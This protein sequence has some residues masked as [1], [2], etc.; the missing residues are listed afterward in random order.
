MI[1]VLG[2]ANGNRVLTGLG[3]TAL[4]FYV[5]AY[6]YLLEET[7]LFKSGVLLATGIVLLATRWLVLNV[8]IK[9]RAD[10]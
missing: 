2:F 3:I 6:Y 10:A 8:V 1:V 7:L 5:S 4:L 9:E